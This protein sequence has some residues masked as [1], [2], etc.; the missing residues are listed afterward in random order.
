[1]IT[2][3]GSEALPRPASVSAFLQLV[4][5]GQHLPMFKQ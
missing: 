4:T 5:R 2:V 3:A 1:M